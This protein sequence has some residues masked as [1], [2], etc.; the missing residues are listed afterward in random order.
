MAT[1]RKAR[2]FSRDA[3]PA[4][5]VI[6]T[7]LTSN[8]DALISAWWCSLSLMLARE[9]QEHS[10][11]G[12]TRDVRESI[13]VAGKAKHQLKGHWQVC[14]GRIPYREEVRT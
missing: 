3:G 1:S 12:S 9:G 11:K 2:D 13:L 7:M 14:F 6:A 8:K 10:C 5:S 4:S